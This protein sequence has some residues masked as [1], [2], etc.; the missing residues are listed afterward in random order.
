MLPPAWLRS[1]TEMELAGA[2]LWL[3]RWSLTVSLERDDPEHPQRGVL[4]H[5]EPLDPLEIED[6]S[7]ELED[8]LGFR[9]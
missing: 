9:A 7:E 5:L 2:R 1:S 8:R 4:E 6:G 3:G